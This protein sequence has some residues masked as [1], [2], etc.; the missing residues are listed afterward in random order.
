MDPEKSG[1][2]GGKRDETLPRQP[3]TQGETSKTAVKPETA[4]KEETL[5]ETDTKETAQEKMHQKTTQRKETDNEK[6]KPKK[7]AQGKTY[8]GEESAHHRQ[9][10]PEESAHEQKET[11]VNEDKHKQAAL[12]EKQV[13]KETVQEDK[14]TGEKKTAQGTQKETAHEKETPKVTA[15]GTQKETAQEKETHKVTAQETQKETAQKKET[16]KV[17]AQETQKETGQ[18]KETPKVTAHKKETPKV[19]AQETQKETAQKK[20]TPKVTA[21]ET[22][23]ET[24]QKK[25]TPKVTAQQKEIPKVTAQETEI[26]KVTAQQKKTPEVTAQEKQTPEV[27]AQEKPSVLDGP[28][29]LQFL[30]DWP[31]PETAQGWLDLCDREWGLTKRDIQLPESADWRDIYKKRPFGRNFLK[32][33]NPEGLST[34]QPPPREECDPPPQKKPLETLGDFRGWQISTEEIPVDRSKVPEGVVV[35]YLPVYSWCVKE[36]VVDLVAEG[37]WEDLLDSYQ[38]D[39]YVLDWYED[40][41]LHRHVYELHVTLLAADK[42]TVISRYDVTPENDMSGDL[43]GWNLVSHVFK[44]YGP[45]VRFIRFLHKSKDLSVLG[46][47]RTRLADST[48]FAQLRGDV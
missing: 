7:T 4:Q 2:A 26:P 33:P 45:G 5:K 39:I 37:L 11:S 40:S 46:F 31:E 30:Q 15:Q 18:K 43:K 13:Q 16:P 6:E 21:Q 24:A 29:Q 28:S 48:V 44:S 20:E 9:Q 10:V 36:Q 1:S 38:P 12:K 32:S 22:Q 17:T 27:T 3:G 47:H 25:E 35:C 19:T 8:G 34:S 41:K 42:T 14:K 23:K